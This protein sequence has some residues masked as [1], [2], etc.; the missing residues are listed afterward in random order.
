MP[1]RVQPCL[2]G[3]L[4]DQL[5]QE[6]ED[7]KYK[8]QAGMAEKLQVSPSLLTLWR[9]GDREP[10]ADLIQRISQIYDR[11]EDDIWFTLRR[12]R[13]PLEAAISFQPPGL[14]H[15]DIDVT[16]AE[17]TGLLIYLEFLRIKGRLEVLP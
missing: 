1:K 13:M 4:L 5:R 15:L 7:P 11:R 10:K 9:K 12:Y 17:K 3:E 8:S 16:P 2:F 14:V 6:E